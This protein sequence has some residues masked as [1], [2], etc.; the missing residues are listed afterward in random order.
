[1][2]R[3]VVRENNLKKGKDVQFKRN[4]WAR[5]IVVCKDTN[6]KYM[7]YGCKCK[8]EES[9][10][11]LSLQPKHTCKRKHKNSIVNYRWIANKPID[12]FVTHPNIH[13]SALLGE[14]KDKWGVDIPDC[15][16]YAAR[17]AND[18]IQGKQ[19]QQYHRI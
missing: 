8:D 7:V 6:C 17:R 9:F 15:Q 10:E 16:L 18:R 5:C 2:F 1:V 13:V 12:K 3:E 14:V 11:I 4:Y 19:I